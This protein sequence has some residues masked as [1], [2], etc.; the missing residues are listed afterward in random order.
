ML[1]KKHLLIFLCIS[2]YSVSLV[3]QTYSGYVRV[4]SSTGIF[5]H[6]VTDSDAKFLGNN[7]IF[8]NILTFPE[9]VVGAQAKVKIPTSTVTGGADT[10]KEVGASASWEKA[11]MGWNLPFYRPLRLWMGHA[12]PLYLP[13]S[14]LTQLDIISAGARWAK[15]GVALQYRGDIIS[16][17]VSV[18]ASTTAYAFF[19]DFQAGSNLQCNLKAYDIPLQIGATLSFKNSYDD[20]RSVSWRDW[21]SAIFAQYKPKFASDSV[22]KS[23]TLTAGYC[24]NGAPVPTNATFKYVELYNTKKNAPEL[25]H[26]HVVTVNT[27]IK[28]SRITVDEEAEVA[29]SFDGG[30]YSLYST[31]RVSV[32]VADWLKLQPTVQYFAV[33]NGNDS[34]RNRDSLTLFP[35][36]VLENGPHQLMLGTK[37]EHRQ[38]DA[39]NY[40]WILKFPAYYRYTL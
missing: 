11:Y 19:D 29:K 21:T 34:T 16:G 35:R 28:I 33:T 40:H 38:M 4:G 10:Y 9:F 17:G 24:I 31:V 26:S 13:G 2:L 23:L 25:Q 20:E 7:I 27:T 36:I 8:N 12:I 18:T 30:Y 22:L 39:D 6:D 1:I 3:A 32:P 37:I 14:Y 5:Q 15:D